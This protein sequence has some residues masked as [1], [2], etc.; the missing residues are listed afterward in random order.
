[1]KRKKHA[2]TEEA[3]NLW[4]KAT[5]RTYYGVVLRGGEYG[6]DDFKRDLEYSIPGIRAMYAGVQLESID[7]H[8]IAIHADI[9]AVSD[10]LELAG[11]MHEG[12]SLEEYL[13]RE[14]PDFILAKR[15]LGLI[16][17]PE[18]DLTP[19]RRRAPLL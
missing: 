5:S 7:E 9:F 8:R 3:E 2:P 19:D 6:I 14:S 18:E 13:L 12:E 10:Y 11:R 16:E 1:M 15:A 4:S 17:I